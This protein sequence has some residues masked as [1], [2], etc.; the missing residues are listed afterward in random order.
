MLLS[1]EDEHTRSDTDSSCNGLGHRSSSHDDGEYSGV[2]DDHACRGGPCCGGGAG[3]SS[4][5][6]FVAHHVD[7]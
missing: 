3:G 6:V 1:D 4:S 7:A 2:D 5:V